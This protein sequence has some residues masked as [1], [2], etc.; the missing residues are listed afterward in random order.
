MFLISKLLNIR[1]NVLFN[2]AK[3]LKIAIWKKNYTFL[4]HSEYWLLNENT[5][6]YPNSFFISLIGECDELNSYKYLKLIS[7][8]VFLRKH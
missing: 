6:R 2:E 1:K 4:L 5:G 3:Y 8:P 7:P